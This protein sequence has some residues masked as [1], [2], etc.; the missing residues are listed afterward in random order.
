MYCVNHPAVE[1]VTLC[2]T[3]G[4]AICQQCQN[5][6]RGVNYCPDCLAKA[7][8]VPKPV[9]EQRKSPGLAGFLAAIVPGLGAL[10]S[11][12]YAKALAFFAVFVGLINAQIYAEEAGAH[13]FLGFAIAGLYVYMIIDGVQSARAIN[14]L[15]PG[16][17]LPE[18]G[19]ISGETDSLGWGITV[20]VIGVLFQ[21]HNLNLFSFSLIWKLWPVIIIVIGIIMLKNYFLG[22]GSKEE[23]GDDNV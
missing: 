18:A 20:T 19:M 16:Q 6:V 7:V 21:L 3:C 1:S 4:K 10:Y 5:D 14:Q 15:Q 22:S 13:V 23:K 12:Q 17:A 2:H 8:E 9:S 11:G